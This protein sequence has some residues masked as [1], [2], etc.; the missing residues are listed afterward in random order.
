MTLHLS[1]I[2]LSLPRLHFLLLSSLPKPL[3]CVSITLVCKLPGSKSQGSFL[4]MPI[5]KPHTLKTDAYTRPREQDRRK[6]QTLENHMVTSLYSDPQCFCLGSMVRK[7]QVAENEA[8]EVQ[9][10]KLY[11][12]EHE[13]PLPSH[14]SPFIV[15]TCVAGCP[16][17]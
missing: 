14:P 5:S 6:A 15:I 7:Q 9:L 17:H 12:M 11:F 10:V 4:K 2:H 13:L 16:C 8:Q 1:P 3:T